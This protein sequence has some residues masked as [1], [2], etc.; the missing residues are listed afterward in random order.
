MPS[1]PSDPSSLARSRT[2]N[3]A[4]SYQPATSGRTRRSTNRATVSRIASSSSP[5]NASVPN[6]P[7][8]DWGVLRAIG[9]LPFEEGNAGVRGRR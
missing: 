3:A 9:G 5:T 2:G 1:T 4:A 8:G 6:R 7:S